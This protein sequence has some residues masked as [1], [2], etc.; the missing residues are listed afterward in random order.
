MNVSVKKKKVVCLWMKDKI[1]ENTYIFE[2]ISID[3]NMD[4]GGYTFK[5]PNYC[6][7]LNCW[8]MITSK[9]TIL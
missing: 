3:M 7:F 2:I 9:G 6:G 4:Q 8:P 5:Q 1:L